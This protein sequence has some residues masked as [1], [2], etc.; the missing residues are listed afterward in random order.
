MEQWVT[1]PEAVTML[2]LSERALRY[3]ISKET[4]ES[5]MEDGRRLVL[6]SLDENLP[7]TFQGLLQEKDAR[8][9]DLTNQNSTLRNQLSEKDRQINEKDSQIDHLTQLMA[10]A[11]KNVGIL[12]EQLKAKDALIAV[13]SQSWWNK[14]V[15][16]F[17][18][19][20]RNQH[21]IG[22]LPV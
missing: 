13:H 16:R 3:R 10:L 5:K 2:G 4:I 12:T 7:A 11:T 22:E 9:S 18:G 1:I 15:F 14:L 6:V 8:I 20:D 17:K 21:T 19:V